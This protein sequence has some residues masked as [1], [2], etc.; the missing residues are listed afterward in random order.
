MVTFLCRFLCLLLFASN[1]LSAQD[2]K[3]TADVE[4][5]V[6]IGKSVRG[7]LTVIHP[8]DQEVQLNSIKMEGKPLKVELKTEV[9]LSAGG[10]GVMSI[11]AF[12]LPAKDKGLHEL[13]EIEL[14]VGTVSHRSVASTFAVEE[15]SSPRVAPAA[16]SQRQTPSTPAPVRRSIAGSPPGGDH[17]LKLEASASGQSPYFPGQRLR[18]TYRYIYSGNVE[19]ASEVLP[20][21]TT[22]DFVKVS[23]RDVRD[24]AEKGMSIREISQEMEA[25]K[26][27]DFNLG[28]SII[29]GY[30][31]TLDAL[32]RKVYVRTKLHAEA[33]AIHLVVKDFPEEGKPISFNGAI[34]QDMAFQA[35]LLSKP[36]VSVGDPLSLSV[37]MQSKSDL[38]NVPLPEL[39][40]QPGFPG[41]LRLS[42][43]PPVGKINGNV[44][45][46]LVELRPL[47]DRVKEI[48]SIEFSYFNPTTQ[49]YTTL[50][51]KPIPIQVEPLPSPPPDESKKAPETTQESPPTN[52]ATAIEIE[53]NYDLEERDVRD[54]FLG[55][56]WATLLLPIGAGFLILQ[57]VIRSDIQR[58]RGLIKVKTSEEIFA[59]ALAQKQPSAFLNRLTEALLMQLKAQGLA[60][61]DAKTVHDLSDE[62]LAGK[63]KRFLKEI[64]RHRFTGKE[65]RVDEALV[66]KS[67]ELFV[68]LGGHLDA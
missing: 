15:G 41:V 24:Y 7:L 52:E 33:P 45:S 8:A 38:K 43:L 37:D 22:Q 66:Q 68:E 46:F 9:P 21:L 12:E 20:L 23:D 59:E 1:L 10:G 48:P 58:R 40:C 2:V 16:P 6:V 65:V 39:C 54:L 61:V 3:V 49:K 14:I 50:R 32:G 4:K 44:K 47:T 62:G 67:K 30:A 31:Y 29:E 60:T 17:S 18:F 25:Q 19:L 27:G 64:E 13:P 36:K 51:S 11:Y 63:T 35:L 42:D 55:T 57:L 56:W 5:P 53:G 26:P 34:G 28:P